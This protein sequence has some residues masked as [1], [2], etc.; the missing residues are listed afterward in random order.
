MDKRKGQE[1]QEEQEELFK[2][3]SNHHYS[4]PE[5][6]KII[7]YRKLL[8][9]IE[10]ARKRKLNYIKYLQ[11]K[12]RWVLRTP[13]DTLMEARLE[14]RQLLEEHGLVSLAGS[15]AE[16]LSWLETQVIQLADSVSRRERFLELVR[17]VREGLKREQERERLSLR[18]ERQQGEKLPDSEQKRRSNPYAPRG[19]RRFNI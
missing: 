6:K 18:K 5:V 17:Q 2:I 8:R 12:G 13:M 14:F 11:R 3:D 9:D 16:T 4:L 19:F 15:E 1:R 10:T 7:R